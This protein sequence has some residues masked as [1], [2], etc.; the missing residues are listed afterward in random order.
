MTDGPVWHDGTLVAPSAP[1]VPATDLGLRHGLGVFETFRVE[2]L[3]TA[4]I[5]AH[6]A[7]LVAGGATL[8]IAVDPDAI[9]AGL[10]TLLRAPH[11]DPAVV[12]VTVTAGDGSTGWPAEPLGHPRTLLTVSAAPPLPARDVDAAI[13]PG[14]RAPAGLA[15][16]KCISYAGSAIATRTARSRGSDIALIEESTFVTEAADGNVLVVRDG[17]LATPAADGRILAGVTRALVLGLAADLGLRVEEVPLRREDLRAADLVLV[18]SAV[19]RLRRVVRVDGV[20]VGDGAAAPHPILDA[21]RAGLAALAAA[22]RPLVP[23]GR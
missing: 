23:P 10:A 5:E 7:R 6:L 16:V 9:R 2:R 14:P 15:D 13:V 20:P 12:R 8:G 1:I 17:V 21:L 11:P 3:R 4:A 18:S 22:A 19:R